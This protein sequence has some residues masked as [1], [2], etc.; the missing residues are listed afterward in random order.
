MSQNI[1]WLCEDKRR[2]ALH[3]FQNCADLRAMRAKTSADNALAAWQRSAEWLASE[4]SFLKG[5]SG[6]EG[7]LKVVQK[8]ID[9]LDGSTVAFSHCRILPPAVNMTKRIIKEMTKRGAA[10]SLQQPDL[11]NTRLEFGP[12]AML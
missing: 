2:I 3:V 6:S 7:V 9:Q 5:L 12:R 11:A 10:A 8:S 1:H 4:T